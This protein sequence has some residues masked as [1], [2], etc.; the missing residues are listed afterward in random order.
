[1][2]MWTDPQ[3]EDYNPM[4]DPSKGYAAVPNY[5]SWTFFDDYWGKPEWKEWYN[6]LKS[7]GSTADAKE[8]WK[9]GWASWREPFSYQGKKDNLSRSL[10]PRESDYPTFDS[11]FRNWMK[12]NGLWVDQNWIS[13]TLTAAD[14]AIDSAGD[15]VQ[16][17]GKTVGWLGRN[18]PLV[19]GVAGIVGLAYAYR[20][21]RG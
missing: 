20:T 1:M 4:F 16:G 2:S 14:T 3:H 8:H 9:K 21:F 13:S 18:L 6:A 19:L 15:I 5:D 12:S 11:D 10:T 7:Q 17:A